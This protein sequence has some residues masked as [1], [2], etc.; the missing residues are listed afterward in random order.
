MARDTH[1]NLAGGGVDAVLETLVVRGPVDKVPDVQAE[2][3]RIGVDRR[4]GG[5]DVAALGDDVG[6][7]RGREGDALGQAGQ[8][9]QGEGFLERRHY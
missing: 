6:R 9:G 7:R 1:G 8:G 4:P 5:G 2:D 3:A